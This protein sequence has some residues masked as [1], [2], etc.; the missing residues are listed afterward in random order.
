MSKVA[1]DAKITK[2]IEKLTSMLLT[3]VIGNAY[4]VFRSII[5]RIAI[6]TSEPAD[7]SCLED[8]H[9]VLIGNMIY[10]MSRT[11]CSFFFLLLFLFQPDINLSH[12]KQSQK[13]VHVIFT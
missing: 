4:K 13:S 11:S 5:Q 8:Q 7:F 2:E 3:V 9:E 12:R 6:S 1:R 10:E